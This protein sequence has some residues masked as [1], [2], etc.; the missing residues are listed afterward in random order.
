MFLNTSP[1]RA[2]DFT[3]FK[4]ETEPTA[5]KITSLAFLSL[6]FLFLAGCNSPDRRHEASDSVNVS[7]PAD[8][9]DFFQKI[10]PDNGINLKHRV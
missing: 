10:S 1:L 7:V 8:N 3:I 2:Y 6:L 4:S 9:G 5:M